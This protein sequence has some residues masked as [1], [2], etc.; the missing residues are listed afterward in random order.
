MGFSNLNASSRPAVAHRPGAPRRFVPSATVFWRRA[1]VSRRSD[2]ADVCLFVTVWFQRWQ[3]RRC[4]NLLGDPKA[5]FPSDLFGFTYDWG[6]TPSSQGSPFPQQNR[7]IQI[8][9]VISTLGTHSR[10]KLCDQKIT[11]GL[12]E[13]LVSSDY[14]GINEDH[15]HRL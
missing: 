11:P 8:P 5:R 10:Q 3:I 13:I 6:A 1:A 2:S 14:N 12:E 9:S 15:L 4:W 7:K